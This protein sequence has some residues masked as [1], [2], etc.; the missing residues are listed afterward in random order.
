MRQALQR[1][2]GGR[3]RARRE[4]EEEQNLILIQRP[5]ESRNGREDRRAG[6]TKGREGEEI[7]EFFRRRN[8]FM[9][10]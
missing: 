8:S 10:K 7:I 9:R 6:R 5:H 3:S 1:R 2:E 4:R